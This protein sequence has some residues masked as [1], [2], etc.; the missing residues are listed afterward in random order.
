MHPTYAPVKL[1][2]LTSGAH[3]FYLG[4]EVF[5][6]NFGEGPKWLPGVVTQV[7]GSWSYSVEMSD[8]RLWHRHVD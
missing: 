4:N 6:R 2:A 7:K 3:Y 5:A 1:E 8:S